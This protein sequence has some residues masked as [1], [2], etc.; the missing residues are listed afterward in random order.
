MSIMVMTQVS[1]NLSMQV[2][3][4]DALTTQPAVHE[5]SQLLQSI[6]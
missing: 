3:E 2:Y 6:N 1:I 4:A 5:L